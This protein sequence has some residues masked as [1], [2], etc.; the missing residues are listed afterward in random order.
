MQAHKSNI[1]DD[2]RT[3]KEE[4]PV[5]LASV[6]DQKDP[7][8]ILKD[9]IFVLID[10]GSCHSCDKDK[11]FQGSRQGNGAGPA[12][13][14]LVSVF[15]F[16]MMI[17]KNRTATFQAPM[18]QTKLIIAGLAYVDDT[19]LVSSGLRKTEKQTVTHLRKMARTWHSSLI[20]SG[21]S[22]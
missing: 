12:I 6:Y 10:S 8:K 21:G 9:K 22:L 14:L 16:K 13:W 2:K 18:S 15:L 17:K 1:L 20:V 7:P 3:L 19:D 11:P 4:T 5:T